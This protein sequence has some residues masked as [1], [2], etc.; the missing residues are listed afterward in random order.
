MNVP[1]NPDDVLKQYGKLIYYLALSQVKNPADAD[2]IFQDVFL[3]LVRTDREFENDEHLKAWLIRVTINRSR[4][5]WHSAW[6]QKMVPLDE[7][8]PAEESEECTDVYEQVLTLPKKYRTVI[9]LFYYEDMSIESIS[10][11]L[12]IGYNAA[13]K[14]L[15]RARNLLKQ[16]MIGKADDNEFSEQLP[17]KCKSTQNSG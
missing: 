3:R 17:E 5:L 9:H 8:L 12:G 11:T 15:S 1:I 16:Q 7:N 2:D 13:A 10:Q 6:K 4:S 14:R